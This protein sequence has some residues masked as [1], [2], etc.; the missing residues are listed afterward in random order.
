MDRKHRMAA[1]AVLALPALLLGA[2][3]GLATASL[4]CDADDKSLKLSAQAVVG[5]GMGEGLSGFQAEIQVLLKG[6]PETL[7]K[8]ELA[9]EHLTQHWVHGREVKLRMYR[10]GP[11]SEAAGSVDLV[12]ETR[13]A[14]KDEPEHRGSYVLT[15]STPGASPGAEGKTLKARGRA[16]CSLG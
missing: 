3:P 1:A 5:H 4:S 11:G 13:A 16:A 6:A 7:R 12:V 9:G 10:D 14:A 2:R 15:V 8:L